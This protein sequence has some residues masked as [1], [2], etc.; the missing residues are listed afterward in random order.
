[1]FRIFYALQELD[2]QQLMQVYNESNQLC[3]GANHKGFD[4]PQQVL[5]AEQ[6]FYDFLRNCFFDG[7]SFYAVLTCDGRYVSAVRLEKFM[8]GLLLE[9]LETAPDC[10]RQGYATLLLH[11]VQKYAAQIGK[12]KIYA[13]VY[14]RNRA[15][16]SLH[17]KCGFSEVLDH[18][19]FIDGSVSWDAITLCCKLCN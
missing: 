5:H 15:S 19:V 16:I 3:G 8:D 14:R 17:K 18:A 6:D 1:M 12:T 4:E 10:R 11:C 2:F 13:H 9:A 7:T